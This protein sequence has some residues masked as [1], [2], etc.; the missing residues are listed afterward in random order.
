MTY[1]TIFLKMVLIAV[2]MPMMYTLLYLK[3][4]HIVSRLLLKT[5]LLQN[6]CNAIIIILQ[7]LLKRSSLAYRN[8]NIKFTLPIGLLS[9]LQFTK[10]KINSALANSVQHSYVLEIS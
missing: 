1:L 4:C 6:C 7:L 9:E 10:K 3:N 2:F 8:K 5:E